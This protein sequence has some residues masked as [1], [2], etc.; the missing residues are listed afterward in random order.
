MIPKILHYVWFGDKKFGDLENMCLESWRKY[1]PDYKIMRWDNSYIDKIEN[2]YFKQAIEN[3]KY[4]FASDYMR[5]KALWEY[6]GIYLDTDEEVLKPLDDFLVHDFF[7]GCQSCGSAKGVNPALIGAVPHNDVVKNLLNV[8]DNLQFINEDG[9]FN[10]T[11]NPAYFEK[12]LTELY[13][14][15]TTFIEKGK[16][17]FHPNSV[18]YDCYLFGK[19][20]DTSFATHHYAG[21]W[22]PDWNMTNKAKFSLFGKNYILRKYK[23]NNRNAKLEANKGE[24]IIFKL[25]VS[26]RSSWVLL[27]KIG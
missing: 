14:I 22:K 18:M 20:N 4:A 5:L 27:Q 13:N 17:E 7:I 23:K 26:K 3:K 1:L 25:R 10:L 8:Y 12:V 19:R 21:S 15:K 16:I 2:L 9:S 6:G 24:K 11:T